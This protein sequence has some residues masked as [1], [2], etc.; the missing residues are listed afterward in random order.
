MAKGFDQRVQFFRA[1]QQMAEHMMAKAEKLDG[2]VLLVADATDSI[3]GPL[4]LA[5]ATK[6]GCA[7]QVIEQQAKL[8]AKGDQIPTTISIVPLAMMIR[9]IEISNPGIAKA[10]E[11]RVPPEFIYAVI[12]SKGGTTLM[13][14][15]KPVKAKAVHLA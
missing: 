5:L 13:V 1:N 2:H 12:I 9:L 7:Q 4:S 8:A 3:G 10:L 6:A 15:K 11:L 14:V